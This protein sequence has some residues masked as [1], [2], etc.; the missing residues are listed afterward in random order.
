MCNFQTM[1]AAKHLT[2]LK[3]H[4]SQECQTLPSINSPVA[5]SILPHSA[6]PLLFPSFAKVVHILGPTI[7]EI[8]MGWILTNIFKELRES[9][10]A[11]KIQ[12]TCKVRCQ[13]IFWGNVD[14]DNAIDD[15]HATHY[16]HHHC[17]KQGKAKSLFA[18]LWRIQYF[19]HC[20]DSLLIR[21]CFINVFWNLV[22]K[23]QQTFQLTW[24][25]KKF[26]CYNVNV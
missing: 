15:D 9:R 16:T 10:I 23:N 17:T 26:Q 25:N 11:S 5:L 20:G 21:T 3:H 22:P 1:N 13:H 19:W 7:T 18:S 12:F 2:L 4:S 14:D 24:Y 6:G 8:I